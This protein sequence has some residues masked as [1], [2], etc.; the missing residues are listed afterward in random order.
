MTH[1]GSVALRP[2]VSGRLRTRIAMLSL[3]LAALG[4]TG[5]PGDETEASSASG[6]PCDVAQV[7][8]D[9][10]ASCHGDTPAFG[11]PMSLSSWS[12]FQA[13]AVSG[14]KVYERVLD[15][16]H[17]VQRPMPPADHAP[18]VASE[19]SALEAWIADGAPKSSAACAPGADGSTSV[20]DDDAGTTDTP[21]EEDLDLSECESVTELR[22][23]G[24]GDPDGDE[25]YAVPME[26]DHYECFAF[27]VPWED[28]RH[29]F[30]IDPLIGDAR[31]VHHWLLY[32]VP[33]MKAG[34]TMTCNGIHPDAT[35][36]SGWAPG[37]PSQ[38]LPPDVGMQMPKGG[39]SSFLLE[40][41]YNNSAR[42]EGATD[43]S[44]VRL[45]TSS[46]LRENEAATHTLGTEALLVP[47]GPYSTGG[48]CSPTK[49]AT[50]LSVSPHMHKLGRRMTIDLYR[51][52]KTT[53]VFDR[54]FDFL[55]QRVWQLSEPLVLEPG[56]RLQTTCSFM[57]DTGT[58]VPYGE[59][60]TNEMC[61]NFVLAYP[62]GALDT[63]SLS[64]GAN[65]CMQ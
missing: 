60:T 65:R 64:G 58:F 27:D 34:T 47:P 7:V 11:A 49:Q 56:D 28:K 22:A 9:K 61:L 6:L 10:C 30:R 48:T 59:A 3:S 1:H 21:S 57:N 16:I 14:G 40:V 29:A 31:V 63:G 36:V 15:R 12:D 45:C 17:D 4:A 32:S 44:G 51:G 39:E 38:V 41:H 8:A 19:Q 25:P 46:K 26:N 50:I 62:P 23:F 43:K 42:Y 2:V 53:T 54:G 18:L 24:G 20:T 13:E 55:D 33:K 37:G 35:L 5:C 52:T